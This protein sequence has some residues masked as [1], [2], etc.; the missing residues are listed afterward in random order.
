MDFTAY[1]SITFEKTKPNNTREFLIEVGPAGYLDMARTFAKRYK[2]KIESIL[3]IPLA[4]MSKDEL[5]AWIE[6][7]N[8]SSKR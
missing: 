2:A 4:G 5:K 1:M 7:K 3:N 6:V 8:P